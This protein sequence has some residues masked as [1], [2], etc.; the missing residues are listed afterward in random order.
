MTPVPAAMRDG[1]ASR[2][3]RYPEAAK[4][5][6][7]QPIPVNLRRQREGGMPD[8]SLGLILLVEDNPVQRRLYGDVLSAQGYT[9]FPAGN[10][11]EAETFLAGNKPE[12][13]LLDVMMPE[14]DGLQ[15][16]HRFR[17]TLGDQIPILF[18]TAAD[19]LDVVLAALKVGG[20]DYI[21]KSGSP[22]LLLERVKHWRSTSYADLKERRSR[23]V[24]YLEDRMKTARAQPG[25]AEPTP[26]ALKH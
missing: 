12:V 16:C 6:K 5:T 15:A 8:Q 13:I 19:N 17:K 2:G 21:V 11:R 22:S 26:A 4:L 23:A 18:L 3:V 9:V 14:V 1:M 24:A 7:T 25:T 10:V 20:D